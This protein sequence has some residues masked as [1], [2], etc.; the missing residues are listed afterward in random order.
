M[1]IRRDM[2]GSGFVL[3]T[4]GA[5]YGCSMIVQWKARRIPRRLYPF[6][7]PPNCT[8]LRHAR[9]ERPL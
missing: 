5:K 1:A 9:K 8:K 4:L 7:E 2:G 6:A 3:A